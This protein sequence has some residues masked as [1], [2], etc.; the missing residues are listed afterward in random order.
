MT[1]PT[2]RPIGSTGRSATAP[3]PAAACPFQPA[4]IAGLMLISGFVGAHLLSPGFAL[5][6]AAYLALTLSYSFGLKRVPL[7]DTLIIGALFTSRLVM[8]IAL[9]NQTYSE[10]LL[11]FSMFFFF[12]LAI[13]KRHTEIVRAGTSTNNSLKSRGYQIEDAPLTLVLGVSSSVASLVIMVLF[14]VEE[15]QQRN[16][17]AYPKVLWAIPIVLSLWV[18][19]SGFSPIV[20]R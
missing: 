14:I 8:G 17:Y 1:L 20:A 4:L 16:L 5:T 2:S 19:A 6:L 11:T 9:A 12:S 13:A 18:A 7:L 3:W 10:W 15:V